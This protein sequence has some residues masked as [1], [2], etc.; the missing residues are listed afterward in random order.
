MD[1]D[2]SDEQYMLRDSVRDFLAKD[3]TPAESRRI[4][5]APTGRSAERWKK[6]GEMGVLGLT[7]PEGYGGAGMDE[8]DLVLVLEESGRNLLPEPLLEHTAVGAPLLAKA[9][10]EAQKSEWLT[11]AAHGDAA[12]SVGL[13]GAPYVQ[14]ANADVIILEEN[15]ELHAATQDRLTLTPVKSVD[16][17][18]RLFKVT[19]ELDA[20][21]RMGDSNGDAAWAFDHAAAATAAQLVG[22]ADAMLQSAIAYAKEREQFGRKIGSFQAIQ[23]KLAETFL[24]VESAK[25]AVYYAAYAL[26]KG[27]DHAP[28]PLPP[29]KPHPP[30][31]DAPP[32]SH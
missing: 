20:E 9:G 2:F 31:P 16:G 22:V 8:I 7:L 17:A 32:H 30:H 14:D 25:S 26:A 13:A 18:R 29:A 15:G 3:C 6:L 4:R 21:T 12:I 10:T 23:H 1:F 24:L 5:E 27:L 28:L 19:A 11:K